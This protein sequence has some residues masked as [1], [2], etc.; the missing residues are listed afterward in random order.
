MQELDI[1]G[2]EKTVLTETIRQDDGK[3][4]MSFPVTWASCSVVNCTL[5]CL[6][7]GMGE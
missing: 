5:T 7:A 4:A 3:G 6:C 1:F 2:V